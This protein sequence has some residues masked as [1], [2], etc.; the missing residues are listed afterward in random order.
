MRQTKN[1]VIAMCVLATASLPTPAMPQNAGGPGLLGF[2]NPG[3]G[4]FQPMQVPHAA[5]A[6]DKTEQTEP[7]PL[8]VSARGGR[9]IIN[10]TIAIVTDIGGA[11]IPSCSGGFSHSTSVTSFS[12]NSFKTGTR[13]GST[14][15][16]QLVMNYLWPQANTSSPVS[17]SFSVNGGPRSVFRNLPQFDLPANGATTTFNVAV[18]I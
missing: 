6:P 17:G 11:T 1:H 12:E 10:I 14:A 2:Y 15:S 4:A 13:N 5:A 8:A 18:R 7:V 3:T 9:F 16:C